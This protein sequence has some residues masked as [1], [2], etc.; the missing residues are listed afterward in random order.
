MQST[1]RHALLRDVQHGWHLM[2]HALANLSNRLISSAGRTF[3]MARV[4]QLIRM[5]SD[6]EEQSFHFRRLSNALWVAAKSQL[7]KRGLT[8]EDAAAIARVDELSEQISR[9]LVLGC[10]EETM[11]KKRI[12]DDL[13]RM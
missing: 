3:G 1:D 6:A 2:I 12:L 11:E 8:A 9:S 5:Y 10:D 7:S 4:F 13:A